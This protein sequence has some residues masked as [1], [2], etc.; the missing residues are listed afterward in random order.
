MLKYPYVACTYGY[1]TQLHHRDNMLLPTTLEAERQ[2]QVLE[3]A[4]LLH[5]NWRANRLNS[6]GVY[7]SRFKPTT[8]ENWIKANGGI[9]EVDIANTSFGDLPED[10]RK[11]NV[12]AAE[13]V[14]DLLKS[15]LILIH[16]GWLD[17][18][19]GLAPEEQKLRYA[20]L[21][22]EDKMKDLLVLQSGIAIL[23]KHLK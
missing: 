21:S 1:L 18:N 23:E 13:Q 6:A 5:E 19:E 10:R 11:E 22:K 2:A 7:E 4:S 9:R 16:E 17:R 12:M 20:A 14:V 15:S 3:I 8:D